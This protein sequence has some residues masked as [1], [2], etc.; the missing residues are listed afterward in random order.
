MTILYYAM[1][2]LLLFHQTWTSRGCHSVVFG[3]RTLNEI[4]ESSVKLED[5][6]T[7]GMAV[8]KRR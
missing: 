5:F 2:Q 1:R 8:E 6:D 3:D 4:A 7:H